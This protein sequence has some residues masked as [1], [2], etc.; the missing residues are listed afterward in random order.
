[1]QIK[2]G[3]A[4]KRISS[5]L[6]AVMLAVSPAAS[7]VTFA[8]DVSGSTGI[9]SGVPAQVSAV[10]TNE[11]AAEDESGEDSVQTSETAASGTTSEDAS[12]DVDKP[13]EDPEANSKTFTVTLDPAGGSLPAEWIETANKNHFVENDD[14]VTAVDENGVITITVSDHSSLYLMAPTPASDDE[15]FAGWVENG[16]SNYVAESDTLVFD[17]NI[18]SYSLTATYSPVVPE[19]ELV[20]NARTYTAI[21]NRKNSGVSLFA[22]DPNAGSWNYIDLVT[23]GFEFVYEDGQ[24]QTFTAPYDGEYIITAYGANGGTGYAKYDGYGVPGRGGMTEATVTL[25]KGQTIYMY[26][27]E[28]GGDWSTERTFGGGGAGVDID[29]AWL[30]SDDGSAHVFGRGGGATYVSIDEFDMS[31]AGQAQWD[32]TAEQ[33]AQNDAAA[34]EAKKHIIMLA[35]G[36]GG[37]GEMGSPY[38]HYGLPGGGYEGGILRH[39]NQYYLPMEQVGQVSYDATVGGRTLTREERLEAWIWPATQ[40]RAGYGLHYSILGNLYDPNPAN[41]DPIELLYPEK[42]A[43]NWGSFFFGSNAMA[44]TGAGG[45]GWFGGGTDYSFDG[46]GGSSYIGTSLTN[47]DGS[48]MTI[49]DLETVAGANVKYD[50]TKSSPFYVN[51]R[52]LIRLNGIMPEMNVVLQEAANEEGSKDH[53][54]ENDIYGQSVMLNKGEDVASETVTYTAIIYY[55]L[56]DIVTVTPA[57]SYNTYLRTEKQP[58]TD[59]VA[60]GIDSRLQVNFTNTDIG[61]PEPGDKYYNENYPGWS[62][63]KSVMTITNPVNSMY[64]TSN[65]IKYYF[66]CSPTAY[67]SSRTGTHYLSAQSLVGGLTIDYNIYLNHNGVHVYD[68]K[69]IINGQEATTFDDT[70]TLTDN[71]DYSVWQYPDLSLIDINHINTILVQFSSH[72]F[73]TRDRIT[74]DSNLANSLGISGSGNQYTYVFRA[75]SKNAVSTSTWEQFLRT[76]QFTTYDAAEFSPN[77]VNGGVSIF[78]YADENLWENDMFYDSTSGHFYAHY[79]NTNYMAISWNDARQRALSAYN[80]ALDCYGYLAH[81]TSAEEQA[82]VHTLMGNEKGW[83]GASR[84]IGSNPWDWYWVDGPA[85]ETQTPFFRQNANG[86]YG[87][88]LW[89]YENWDGKTEPNN[90]GNEYVMHYYGD[91]GYWNDYNPTNDAVNAYIVEWSKDGLQD[92]D[93]SVSDTDT[94]GT[95]VIHVEDFSSTPKYSNIAG[96]VWAENDGNGIYSQRDEVSLDGITVELISNTNNQTVSTTTTGTYGEYSFSTIPEGSYKVKFTIP[97]GKITGDYLPSQKGTSSDPE[98]VLN[99]VNQDYATDSFTV[100]DGNDVTNANCAVYVPS[101]ISGYVWDDNKTRD[102]IFEDEDKI[103]GLHVTLYNG[104]NIALDAYGNQLTTTTD[105]NGSYRFDNVPAITTAYDVVITS[106]DDISIAKATVSPIPDPSTPADIANTASPVTFGDVSAS[107]D[108]EQ[109]VITNL[110][111]PT[112]G[113]DLTAINLEY[114][115]CALNVRNTVWG[116]VWA[117]T[118][119][120]GILNGTD[121]TATTE[122]MLPKVKVTLLNAADKQ[123]SQTYTSQTGYYEFGDIEPGQYKLHF[124]AA[125]GFDANGKL[126][127]V[128]TDFSDFLAAPIPEDQTDASC[129][130][131]S[132]KANEQHVSTPGLPELVD[133]ITDE[134]EVESAT[135]TN[136]E[137]SVKNLNAALFAPSDVSGIIWEDYDQDGLREDGEVLLNG[138]SATLL[139]YVSGNIEDESSYEPYTLPDGKIATIQS[140]QY[141]NAQ[142]GVARDWTQPGYE[143]T[144]HFYNLPS[145]TYAVRFESGNFDIRYYIASPKNVGDDPS[146]DSDVVGKY[147]EDGEQFVSGITTGLVIPAQTDMESY[148]FQLM[149]MDFG[150]YQKLR[151]V[152]VTKQISADEIVWAHGEPTFL[153]TVHGTTP[154]GEEYTFNHMYTFTEEYVKANTDENGNVSMTYLFEGIPYAYVYY[155][156]EQ[157]SLRY[158][159]SRMSGTE[160]VTVEDNVAAID[161][162]YEVEGTVNVYNNVTDYSDTSSNDNATN[163]FRFPL[164]A[165][166]FG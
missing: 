86:V 30:G 12:V 140:G 136:P 101:S 133:L 151:D 161:L 22:L 132:A 112:I 166:I 83:L 90:A 100:S 71:H 31:N 144:Y 37:A 7:S 53:I 57:W 5:L 117:E 128:V 109:A 94:I 91:T 23:E 138:V 35:A 63:I 28:A 79:V 129:Y 3:K 107:V 139:R 125:E 70:V 120:D 97:D 110:Y 164:L 34:A 111:I 76:I 82:F 153:I 118:D 32:F 145:G 15:Y 142:D 92:N 46:G 8:E 60:K 152:T 64:D 113:K 19:S 27:G 156:E 80:S 11:S 47:A 16:T 54:D 148:N 52:V 99:A 116:Y 154:L 72:D 61:I 9:D 84:N 150:A 51:G 123:V 157:D 141:M 105:E 10:A 87:T 122:N 18:E 163:M 130:Y 69:N 88:L 4:A 20:E 89:G 126:P 146:I 21:E 158:A 124:E 33:Q 96:V 159:P 102:G 41:K 81:I 119:N 162:K 114:K 39:H 85:S 29:H 134:F 160:N 66:S 137:D 98:T 155:V 131:N 2:A 143:G 106:G 165:R 56:P 44:C 55:T 26:I 149:H 48:V 115:N 59:A 68:D 13:V 42:E 74:Y 6:L 121:I 1:M 50:N 58:W 62:A 25:K 147:T 49:S 65:T 104:D 67:Y 127:N 108:L 14:S 135:I 24:I 45:G 38:S 73:D 78:W 77:G 36:G 17:S 103:K 40:T 95:Q 43:R 75:K 93:H